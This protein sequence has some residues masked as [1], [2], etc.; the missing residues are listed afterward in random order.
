MNIVPYAILTVIL[1]IVNTI[2]PMITSFNCLIF[3]WIRDR[4]E[5]N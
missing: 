1:N 4:R 3:G 5:A 2:V